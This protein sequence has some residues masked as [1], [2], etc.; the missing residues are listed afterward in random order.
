GQHQHVGPL[1]ELSVVFG[2]VNP[3]LVGELDESLFA[4]VAGL[5]LRRRHGAR[6]KQS[7]DQGAG[8]VAR[9]QKAD[10]LVLHRHD[11]AAR[12][13]TCSWLSTIRSIF[14]RT[15][16]PLLSARRSLATS[17]WRRSSGTRRVVDGLLWSAASHETASTTL[18]P[19]L[20]RWKRL[21]SVMVLLW[22]SADSGS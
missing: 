21:A 3:V 15:S 14:S 17:S 5:N 8:H 11:L 13:A 4:H 1:R 12:A 18:C 7:L 16:A 9:S 2:R 19:V 6:M 20:F 22:C 10:F